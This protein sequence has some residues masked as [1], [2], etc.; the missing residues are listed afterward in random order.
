MPIQKVEYTPEER[1]NKD[2]LDCN[3]SVTCYAPSCR[4]TEYRQPVG[5][6]CR[7]KPLSTETRAFIAFVTVYVVQLLAWSS[8]LYYVR[9]QTYRTGYGVWWQAFT[10]YLILSLLATGL[11]LVPCGFFAAVPIFFFGVKQ[12]S[13]VGVMPAFALTLGMSLLLFAAAAFIY[14]ALGVRMSGPPA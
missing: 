11:C 5:P 12:I 8:V 9:R 1:E 2:F 10:A 3:P 14:A 4:T 13:G 7:G 6:T